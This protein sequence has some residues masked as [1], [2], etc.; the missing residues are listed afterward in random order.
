MF[1]VYVLRSE[2]DGDLYVGCTSDL[3]KRID[4]HRR[5]RVRSTKYRTPLL[6]IYQENFGNK[7]EAFKMERFY[8][9]AKGKKLLKEK[10]N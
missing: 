1:T 8:K 10:I 7:Y 5:G 2:K 4:Y 3:P 9:T 6:L